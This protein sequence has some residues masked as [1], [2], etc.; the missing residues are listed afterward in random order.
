M[1]LVLT[2]WRSKRRESW[3]ENIAC[4][5]ALREGAWHIWGTGSKPGSWNKEPEE[6]V[7][8]IRDKVGQI[9]Q[10]VIDVK[11]S[12]FY[13]KISEVTMK[14]LNN[15]VAWLYCILKWSFWLHFEE[16]TGRWKDRCEE[17]SLEAIKVFQVKDHGRLYWVVVEELGTSWKIQGIF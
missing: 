11:K 5:V 1:E 10:N 4:T 17:A 16:N 12:V 6:G 3:A 15:R 2:L 8:W 9:I 14:D 7:V 13:P